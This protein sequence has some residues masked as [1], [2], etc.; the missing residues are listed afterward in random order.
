MDVLYQVGNFIFRRSLRYTLFTASLGALGVFAD[1]A[2]LPGLTVKQALLFPLLIGGTALVGGYLLRLVPSLISVRLQVRA[3]GSDLN[4]MEDHR[5]ADV[6][7]HLNVFWER[8]FRFECEVQLKAG[9]ALFGGQ[10]V[11]PEGVEP[12]PFAREEF[13]ERGRDAMASAEPQIRQMHRVGLDLRYLEDWRDGAW[14]DRNDVKLR[15]QFDGNGTLLAARAAAGFDGPLVALRLQPLRLGQKF[16]FWFVTRAIAMN[17][18]GA[19][20]RLNQRFDTDIINAQVLLWPGEEDEPWLQQIPGATEEVLAHRDAVVRR[21]FGP[22]AHTAR[23][24][25]DHMFYCSYVEATELRMRF[26]PE[27]C[28][29]SLSYGVL[30]DLQ[31][32][33]AQAWHLRQAKRFVARAREALSR[34][35]ADVAARHSEFLEPERAGQ[36]RTARG[37]FHVSQDLDAALEGAADNEEAWTRRLVAVR[38]HH[39]LARLTLRGYESLLDALAYG[40]D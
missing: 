37:V 14:F 35:D 36:L 29:G 38:M 11:P 34:F 5:R 7:N 30:D 16:W 10:V 13:L 24:L 12:L 26:D 19:V 9:A 1:F 8:I 6:E 21:V 23:E 27:F 17:V 20:D 15:E 3:Q 33:R 31:A 39:E 18:A 2:G 22:T 4:L 40:D 25:L 32:D 28:E